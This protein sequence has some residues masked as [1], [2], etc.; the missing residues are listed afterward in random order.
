MSKRTAAFWTVEFLCV[1][2]IA[3]VLST[4]STS[5]KWWTLIP[6]AIIILIKLLEYF[7]NRRLSVNSVRYQLKVLVRLLP[8]DGSSVRCTY[9]LPVHQK[10]R[11]RT[12]LAQAFD[13]IPD[14]GG[15]GRRFPIE[16]GII[17]KVYVNKGARCENFGSDHE[18]RERMVK[19][20]NYTAS[21]VMERSADRRSYACYPIVDESH[22]VLGLIYLDSDQPNTFTVDNAN[23]TWLMIRE[24]GEVI[25]DNILTS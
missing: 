13:Y 23:P 4:A 12:Q 8:A 15:G 11:N 22:N 18:Y 3:V 14:G 6:A 24:A 7:D 1:T 16:K 5:A 10:F 17:G 19:E 2:A 25:R 21:E 20:Y 9:H